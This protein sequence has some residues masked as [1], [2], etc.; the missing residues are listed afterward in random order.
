MNFEIQIVHLQVVNTELVLHCRPTVFSTRDEDVRSSAVNSI[1][2]SL[3]IHPNPRTCAYIHI[4]FETQNESCLHK[5]YMPVEI[6]NKFHAIKSSPIECADNI[7][8]QGSV[9]G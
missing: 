4:E 9:Y 6:L 7:L 1:M 8:V 3:S 2:D 5:F